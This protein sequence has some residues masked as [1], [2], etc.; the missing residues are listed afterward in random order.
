MQNKNKIL[1]G[2]ISFIVLITIIFTFESKNDLNKKNVLIN[3]NNTNNEEFLEKESIKVED[4]KSIVTTK[5]IEKKISNENEYEDVT[6]VFKT[7]PKLSDEHI[8]K[9]NHVF[10]EFIK[11]YDK[12]IYFNADFSEILNKKVGDEVS[13]FING[14]IYEG[15]IK[16]NDIRIP[17]EEEIN[18]GM[19][20]ISYDIRIQNSI[21]D[22]A[23][24]I[25]IGGVLNPETNEFHFNG[26]I[27]YVKQKGNTLYRFESDNN[28]GVMV[29][30]YDFDNYLRMDLQIRLD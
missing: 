24:N 10:L 11:K 4:N 8:S 9:L 21:E 22:Y 27:D 18:H 5:I 16:K 14:E 12:A 17:S 30:Y 1:V 25:S 26:D 3:Q 2:I 29:P 19:N 6:V 13:L 23:N 28:G 7:I 20:L 15:I